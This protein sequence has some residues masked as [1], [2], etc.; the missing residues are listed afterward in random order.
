MKKTGFLL[1]FI[2]LIS[3]FSTSCRKAENWQSLFNGKDLS[4]WDMHLGTS[5]GSEFDHLAGAATIEKVFSL[6]EAD[7][8]KL[9]R[10]SGEINGSLATKESFENYHLRLIF[11]WGE[12]VYSYHNS[13]LLYHSFGEFGTALGT[14]MP[15]IEFQLM[16]KNI[17]DTYLMGNTTC[18]TSVRKDEEKNQY[19]YSPEAEVLTFGA[20]ANGRMIRK[21]SDNENPEGE[22]NIIDL[23]CSGRTSVH[24]V[25][26]KTVMINTNTGIYENGEITALTKGKIQLQSEGGELFIKSIDIRPI[27]NLPAN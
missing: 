16:K 12:N 5:L 11:K 18:E 20:H 9:I 3:L 19:I 10:I 21:E 6:V 17:G 14:W 23:Y 26:G 24:M 1:S 25:N 8:E 4:N 15:N 13:G 2:F 7:G 22:W 27:K